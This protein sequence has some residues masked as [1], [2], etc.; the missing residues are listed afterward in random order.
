MKVP[1]I[2]TVLAVSC[3]AGLVG[4]ALLN[5]VQ[6]QRAQQDKK[7]LQ[8]EITDL[9]YE[10]NLERGSQ[11]TPTPEPEASASPQASPA[12][13]PTPAPEVAGTA[14]VAIPVY[15]LKLTARD[16]HKLKERDS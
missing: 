10:L 1:K 5:M 12:A 16:S 2:S 8:G 15:G 13:S 14:S 6:F 11:I 3:A 7:L 9:R 4:S